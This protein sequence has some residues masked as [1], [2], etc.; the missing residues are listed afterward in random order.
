MLDARLLVD[1]A[2]RRIVLSSPIFRPLNRVQKLMASS[3]RFSLCH[4]ISYSSR[5]IQGLRSEIRGQKSEVGD[6]EVRDQESEVEG[7]KS[8][9]RGSKLREADFMPLIGRLLLLTSEPLTSDLR[10]PI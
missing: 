2:N 9:I 4:W 8:G 6:S 7:Q 10:P 1:S 3:S 5:K